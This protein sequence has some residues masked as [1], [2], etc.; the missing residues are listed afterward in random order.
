MPTET[1]ILS[2][3][4]IMVLVREVW[5]GKSIARTLMNQ[6][7]SEL[8]ASG[9][10]LDLGSKSDEA[11]YNRFLK[12]TDRTDGTNRTNV[13]YTDISGDGKNVVR[14]DLEEPFPLDD[15]MYD[16]VTCFNT[17][18][19]IY[20]YQNV[21]SESYRILKSGGLF[22]GGTPF[23]V[24]FHPDPHDYFRYTDEAIEKIFVEAG[25]APERMVMLG[26]GPMTAGAALILHVFPGFL[27]PLMA[28][29]AVC[30][31]AV[32]L[33]YKTSQRM[34]YA[35]GYVYVFRKL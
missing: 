10:I 20:N 32:I 18:E 25:F 30:V 21:V 34:K 22:I 31:D 5:R 3:R 11:S 29:A 26:F 17:L 28:L 19:H 33:K 27:R 9:A 14:L 35:L 12:L 2:R 8:T 4:L 24:N 6:A 13:T 1:V 15:S 23:L 16:T 7:V